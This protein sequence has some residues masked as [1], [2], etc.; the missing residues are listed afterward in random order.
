ML[1][2][3]CNVNLS[4]MSQATQLKLL[5][6]GAVQWDQSPGSYQVFFKP[7]CISAVDEVNSEVCFSARH[8]T[9]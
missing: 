7:F 5:L 2:C 8:P 1:K 9:E 4:E 6:Q 3:S